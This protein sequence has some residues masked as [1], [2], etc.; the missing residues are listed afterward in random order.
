MAWE[1]SE[2]MD[3]P[4]K[5]PKYPH[6]FCPASLVKFGEKWDTLIDIVLTFF[7]LFND[8][9]CI[10]GN[11]AMSLSSFVQNKPKKKWALCLT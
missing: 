4:W 11:I 9:D 8:K 5:Y 1:N 3:F 6:I 7:G 2:N 10:I